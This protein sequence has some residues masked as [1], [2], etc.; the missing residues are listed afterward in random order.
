MGEALTRDGD[1][2]RS[3][4]GGDADAAAR[5]FERHWNAVWRAAYALLGSRAHADDAAQN[6]FVAAF[7]RLDEFEGRSSFRTWVTRI[8]IN[9]ALNTLRRETRLVRLRDEYEPDLGDSDR[10]SAALLDAL[11]ALSLERRTVIVLRYWLG[12]SIEE[13]AELLD[14]PS[15]TVSSRLAR[16]LSELRAALEVNCIG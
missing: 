9:D 7:S 11:D 14:V 6:A 1:L 12:C 4:T 8:A 10:T 13:I 2:V 15:G 5:L 16:G 3:A